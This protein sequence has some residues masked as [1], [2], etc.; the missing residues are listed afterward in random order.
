MCHTTIGPPA[1][2]E[3]MLVEQGGLGGED[4]RYPQGFADVRVHP[5]EYALPIIGHG[6]K[7]SSL[8]IVIYKRGEHTPCR[9]ERESNE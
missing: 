1:G 9:R 8:C 6:C 5:L 7:R 3:K 4:L 2:L